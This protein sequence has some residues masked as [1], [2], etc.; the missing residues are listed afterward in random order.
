M[1]DLQKITRN[2]RTG[3]AVA[4]FPRDLLLR[5]TEYPDLPL[6]MGP[7]ETIKAGNTALVLRANLPGPHGL[8]SVAYKR[9]TRKTSLKRISLIFGYNP[10]LRSFRIGKLIASLGIPTAK[11]LAVIVPSRLQIHQPSWLIAEWVSEATTLAGYAEASSRQTRR[12]NVQSD[13]AVATAVGT[14][15]GKLHANRITHRDLKPQNVLVRVEAQKHTAEAFLIDLDGAQ[16]RT[17]IGESV[18][19]R[20]LS[21][22]AVSLLPLDNRVIHE[23]LTAYLNAAGLPMNRKLAWRNLQ[24]ATR[25]RLSHRKA[26]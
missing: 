22:L 7:A 11:P 23:F 3:Y 13:L 4:E 17:R 6:R 15:L 9:V 2:G 18:R 8:V 1:S 26:A 20:N 12:N 5:L 25:Q 19:W 10:T 21:R 24:T 16:V 14:M